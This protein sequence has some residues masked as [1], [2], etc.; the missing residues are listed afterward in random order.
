MEEQV[1]RFLA[2][3]HET[4]IAAA[5][6]LAD[7]V[8]RARAGDAEAVQEVREGFAEL[9]ALMG[10]GLAPRGARPADAIQESM[11]VLS[12]LAVAPGDGPFVVKLAR[13]ISARLATI[14]W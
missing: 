1:E 8:D 14:S 9:A 13:A 11:L 10:L 5:D 3:L 7:A 12:E 2:E 4:T 6:P